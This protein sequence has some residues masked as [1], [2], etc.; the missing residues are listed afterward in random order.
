MG[1]LPSVVVAFDS[2]REACRRI[3]GVS[4]AGRIVRELAEAGLAVAWLDLPAGETLDAAATADVRRLAGT[5]EVRNGRPRSGES[6][7]ELP[8]DRL[9]GA[10]AVG[11]VARGDP[12][13]FENALDLT[14]RD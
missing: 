12:T 14:R 7:V 8:G 6:F 5:M 13:A 9:I 4:A 1:S 2:V 10:T 3:A 11:A